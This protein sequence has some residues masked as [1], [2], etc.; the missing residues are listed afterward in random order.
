MPSVNSFFNVNS[1]HEFLPLILP[2]PLFGLLYKTSIGRRL[3]KSSVSLAVECCSYA[4]LCAGEAI[5]CDILFNLHKS[6]VKKFFLFL[7]A[8]KN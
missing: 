7:Y 1:S 5:Y 4:R 3:G 6:I 2:C 8:V